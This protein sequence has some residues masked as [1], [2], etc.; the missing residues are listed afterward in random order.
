MILSECYKN[1]VSF[2]FC[3]RL[4]DQQSTQTVIV[5][6]FDSI[7]NTITP[8][9]K[10]HFDKA[11][12]AWELA[13]ILLGTPLFCL[14]TDR[15]QKKRGDLLALTFCWQKLLL[16]CSYK[17]VNIINLSWL[18]LKK[19]FRH[20]NKLITTTF[21][22]NQ[23]NVIRCEVLYDGKNRIKIDNRGEIRPKIFLIQ[24]KIPM[25]LL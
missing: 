15:N 22:C 19:K 17:K 14:I 6:Y 20:D 16:L 8:L 13:L 7:V 11:L 10:Q 4:Y 21:L 12:I 23:C 9:L 3:I 1:P 25:C 2:F 24:N 18:K 5:N